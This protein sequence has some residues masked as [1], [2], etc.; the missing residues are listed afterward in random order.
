M[1]NLKKR[2]RIWMLPIAV[3]LFS[4]LMTNCTNA[5]NNELPRTIEVTGSAEMAINPDLIKLDVVITEDFNKNKKDDFLKILK[6]NGVT[7]DKI[8]FQSQQENWWYY[9][10]YYNHTEVRYTITVD[11]TVNAMGLMED[12]KE[13]WVRRINISEKTNT[14]LQAYRKEVKIEAVKAAKEKAAYMLEALGEELGAVISIEEVNTDK[15]Q[16]NPCYWWGATNTNSMA[17]NSVVSSSKSGNNYVPGV[18][19]QKLRYEV[20][21][22]FYIK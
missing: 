12:L 1:K 7:D 10:H 22:T 9:Y 3:T 6:K 2:L 11:S 15:N 17:S 19:M 4:T 14:Q 20:K 18:S 21:I 5:Q 13:P 16:T 8:A